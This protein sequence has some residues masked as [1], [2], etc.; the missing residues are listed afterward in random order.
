MNAAED[1]V[2]PNATGQF[3]KDLMVSHLVDGPFSLDRERLEPLISENLFS[4]FQI[5]LPKN[6]LAQA[7][8]MV[9]A[10]FQLR[11]NPNYQKTYSAELEMRGIK[12]PGNKAICMSYDFHLDQDGILKLI[13]INT[14]ASF[15]QYRDKENASRGYEWLVMQGLE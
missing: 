1:Q 5:E 13:E 10:C 9:K 6:I 14:N 7:Q 2:L 11:E 4:P 12:D 3:L 8:E 15:F